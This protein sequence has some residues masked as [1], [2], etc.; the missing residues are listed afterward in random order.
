[1]LSFIVLKHFWTEKKVR[2]IYFDKNGVEL[3]SYNFDFPSNAF[4]SEDTLKI[5][6]DE[7]Q[8]QVRLYSKKDKRD[9]TWLFDKNG[10]IIKEW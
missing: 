5:F 7:K 6:E 2:L 4:P 1:M 9:K 10:N 8:I 3:W